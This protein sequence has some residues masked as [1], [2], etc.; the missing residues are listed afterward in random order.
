MDSIQYFKQNDHVLWQC[1]FIWVCA[2]CQFLKLYISMFEKWMESP[3]WLLAVSKP[4]VRMRVTSAWGQEY[5]KWKNH[6]NMFNNQWVWW[7]YIFF[8][9]W[10]L[11]KSYWHVMAWRPPCGYSGMFW[12]NMSVAV[13]GYGLF[14]VWP[15]WPCCS[16]LFV[17]IP[18]YK[19]IRSLIVININTSHI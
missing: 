4:K 1:L 9:L 7:I 15:F 14:T 2:G 5:H 17:K 8:F 19:I 16:A 18:H 13:F 3:Q 12:P 6:V 11:Q 10:N